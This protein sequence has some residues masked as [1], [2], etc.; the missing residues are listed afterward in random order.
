MSGCDTSRVF[1]VCIKGVSEHGD[2]AA[3]AV[4]SV[5][6]A[7]SSTEGQVAMPLDL[8]SV[9][10][11]TKQAKQAE[12]SVAEL[13]RELAERRAEAERAKADAEQARKAEAARLRQATRDAATA[14]AALEAD[15][16]RVLDDAVKLAAG[17]PDHQ[18]RVMARSLLLGN[19]RGGEVTGGPHS[20]VL[21]RDPAAALLFGAN[22]QAAR[23]LQ[24]MRAAGVDGDPVA[25]ADQVEC[26]LWSAFMAR[27][28]A[29][30]GEFR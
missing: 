29:L 20:L 24:Q 19:L 12:A 4:V 1:I 8:A 22:Q 5:A 11:A 15:L 3:E 18:T 25:R 9:G 17:V 26:K 2:E 7:W 6:E 14:A 23:S 27:L 13:E 30:A 10:L 21:E 28:R 16:S